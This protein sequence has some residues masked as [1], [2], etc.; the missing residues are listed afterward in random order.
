MKKVFMWIGIIVGGIFIFGVLAGIVIPNYEAYQR[1]DEGGENK[2][3]VTVAKIPVVTE[4][5]YIASAKQVIRIDDSKKG[6]YYKEFL[7]NPNKFTGVRL[8]ILGK[9]MTIE[10]SGGKTF[11]QMYISNDFDSIVVYYNGNTSFY[12]DDMIRVYGD[13]AGTIDGRN[14]MGASMTWPVIQAKYLKK[15]KPS[16]E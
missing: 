1:R 6:I 3:Q 13:G 4:A 10:E 5:E 8:N 15:F 12:K 11:I 7:K 16:I 2:T 9:I 14:R